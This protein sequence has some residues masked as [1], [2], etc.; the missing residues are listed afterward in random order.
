MA[1][2]VPHRHRKVVMVLTP[3]L[4]VV[5]WPDPP[6]QD[7]GAPDGGARHAFSAPSPLAGE[8]W[9]EGYGWLPPPSAHGCA[10]S[11]PSSRVFGRYWP[12]EVH[13][14]GSRS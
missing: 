7:G 14:A 11:I 1:A 5:A 12:I 13:L 6:T 3:G 8:G 10:V 9:G 4:L 2:L